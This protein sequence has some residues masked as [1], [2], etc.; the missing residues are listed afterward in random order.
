MISRNGLLHL[1]SAFRLCSG[2]LL[3]ISE[4]MLDY[5]I[6]QQSNNMNHLHTNPQLCKYIKGESQYVCRHFRVQEFFII[7]GSILFCNS[8]VFD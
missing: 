1:M 7:P 5:L 6:T 3:H 8:V 4:S 2:R